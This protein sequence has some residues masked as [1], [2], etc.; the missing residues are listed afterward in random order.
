MSTQAPRT[1]E[2]PPRQIRTGSVASAVRSLLFS[3]LSSF[4]TIHAFHS[5]I[6][7]QPLSPESSEKTSK[8]PPESAPLD[9][10]PTD[11][12]AQ[13]GKI[14][15]MELAKEEESV[16]REKTSHASI[17]RGM[18]PSEETPISESPSNVYIIT[19]DDI[20]QSGAIDIPTILRSVPGIE[21]MQV[22]GADFNVSARGN[23]Q[24]RANKM[25]V[26]VDGRSIYLD[27]QGE[28]LW[29]N[30][31][32]T[33]PEIKRIE[34]LKGPAG[35]IYGF[36][37]FDGVI[38]IITKSAKEIKGS[39][40][41]GGILQF[42]GG[43]F[44]TISS[45]AIVGVTDKA[46]KWGLRLSAG[47]NQ[48]NQWNNRDSLA[49]R[50]NLF[51]GQVEHHFS[52]DSKVTLQGGI[53]D[54]NRYMGPW[55]DALQ[56]NQQPMQ[57]YTNVVYERP[58]FFIR[59]FW[60]GNQQP[61]TLTANPLVAQ[62]FRVTDNNGNTNLFINS[63]SYNV[64]VQKVLSLWANN[65]LTVGAN[66]RYNTASSNFIGGDGNAYEHRVGL[67][68]QDEWRLTSNLTAVAG[69]R[70]DID[71]FI[72]PTISPRAAIIYSP[73]TDHTFRAEISVG[74]RPP[75]IFE[76]RTSNRGFVSFTLPVPPITITTP[77]QLNGNPNLAPEQIISYNLGYQGWYWKHRVRARVDGFYNH[78][79]D[80]ISIASF[81]QTNISFA[82]GGNQGQ[83]ALA[84]TAGGGSADIYGGEAGFEV[85]PR[86]WLS[87]F[88]NTS[89]VK[90]HQ[91]YS[92][93]NR[94]ARGAPEWK[95]NA[96]IRA[97]HE[98]GLNG[99]LLL[100]Y[101]AA[102]TYPV[103]PF[104]QTAAAPPFNGS[105]APLNT[106][107]SYILFNPRVAWKFWREKGKGREAEIA[108]AGF[109]AINDKHK[110]SPIGETIGSRWMGWLTVRY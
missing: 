100:H 95:A 108:V 84:G 105:P 35:A 60:T 41:A 58:D 20:R 27:V 25:L 88:A 63:N 55:V 81:S 70:Y 89:L 29:K 30:I 86:P 77:T 7:A 110:E 4:L 96:G 14:E 53:V 99:Q 23:N 38:N 11:A 51:N 93:N 72:N 6:L 47:H 52:D 18:F 37:A 48:T 79:S 75:T 5:S 80:L 26:L 68:L 1:T 8:E 91:T 56:T 71:S 66:Y 49:F 46:E 87:A 107:G 21:V 16:A 32:V 85:W 34:V 3:V 106:V 22:T 17:G 104:F 24:L 65:R 97:E 62:F 42:G 45:A 57:R 15:E 44:G 101:V 83:G 90:I 98:S 19:D 54:S 10:P 69:L 12:K 82:N 31:P 64:E 36:N 13:D 78:I 43:E 109:N 50:N 103:D 61:G 94:V 39:S 2:P 59:A 92:L 73:W 28:V 76:T 102:A 74:Y 9:L 67:Y 33:L 40:P